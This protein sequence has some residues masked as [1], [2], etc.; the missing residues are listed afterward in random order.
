MR[1]VL[2]FIVMTLL[3]SGCTRHAVVD[4]QPGTDFAQYRT[5]A[6]VEAGEDSVRSLDASRIERAVEKELSARGFDRVDREEADLLVRYRVDHRLRLETR[7]FG[8][9]L[10][11]H[12]PF[13]HHRRHSL[14]G[15]FHSHPDFYQVD[16]A[17]LIV[18][19]AERESR[20]VIWQAVGQR[21]LTEYMKPARRQAVIA[22]QITEM[23]EQYPPE[24]R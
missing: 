11:F 2:V 14:H 24:N 1:A 8:Y 23:F 15:A 22:R 7:G 5:W 4:H 18:E 21:T 13:Y 12:D 16:E 6:W 3:A 10:G 17:R 20:Q 19:L 9:G